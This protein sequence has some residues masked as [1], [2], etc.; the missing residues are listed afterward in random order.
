MIGGA[1]HAARRTDF[2]YLCP[3]AQD[4]A[5]LLAYSLQAV[6]AP[7]RIA[8]VGGEQGEL[9]ARTH[10]TVAVAAGDGEH[11]DTDLHS[12][13]EHRPALDGLLDSRVRAARVAHAGDPGFD[14]A[15]H[16]LNRIVEAQRERRYHITGDIDAF[17]HEM[18]VRINEARQNK[19]AGGI[20]LGDTGGER[21]E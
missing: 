13:A 19:P 1:E 21:A 16:V 15:A 7:V 20:Y 9:V 18:H 12:R 10:P 3:G 8:W 2:D 14:G 6:A 4:L 17:Q 5:D 11:R